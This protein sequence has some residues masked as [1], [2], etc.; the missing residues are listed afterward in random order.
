MTLAPTD[1][2]AMPRGVRIHV[3][4]VRNQHVLLAPERAIILDP[5]GQA[6]LGELDGTRSFGD[7][8]A[9]LAAKYE[10]PI[11]QITADCDEFISALLDRR[12][13]ELMP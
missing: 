9:G 8:C 6:I 13:L 7:I 12:I 1:I 3:D 10:A 11:D 5:I 2:P 4:K